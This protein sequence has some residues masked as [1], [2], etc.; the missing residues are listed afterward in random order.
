MNSLPL[1]I[2]LIA[3]VEMGAALVVA[4]ATVR[5]VKT[6]GMNTIAGNAPMNAEF[7]RQL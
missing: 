5:E 6:M 4:V 3:A 2:S 1:L 7:Q